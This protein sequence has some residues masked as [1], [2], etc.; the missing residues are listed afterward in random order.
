MN[1]EN[2]HAIV[3]NIYIIYIPLNNEAM[4]FHC[5]MTCQVIPLES[6]MKYPHRMQYVLDAAL[7]IVLSVNL[8]FAIYGYLLFGSATKGQSISNIHVVLRVRSSWE[9]D[10]IRSGEIGENQ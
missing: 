9:R 3:N 8:P 10:E 6:V 7:V 1:S 5:H 2:D 4:Y